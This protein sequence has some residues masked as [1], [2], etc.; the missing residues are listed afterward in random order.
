MNIREKMRKG[1][2]YT[3]MYEEL[4]DERLKEKNLY[5][6]IITHALASKRNVVKY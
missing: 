3:D 2:L 6:I 1:M 4:P 5:M